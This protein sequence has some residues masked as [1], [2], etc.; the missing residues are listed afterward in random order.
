M[1]FRDLVDPRKP[2]LWAVVMW[3]A[4]HTNKNNRL[5]MERFRRCIEGNIVSRLSL[6]MLLLDRENIRSIRNLEIC[7]LGFAPK[8]QYETLGTFH[9]FVSVWL[10]MMLEV[11]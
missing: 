8:M 10:Y 3:V 6:R 4:S 11:L 1:S 7:D 9:V 5:S 2:V